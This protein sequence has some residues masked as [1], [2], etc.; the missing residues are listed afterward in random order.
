MQIM[1]GCICAAVSSSLPFM[2]PFFGILP[3]GASIQRQNG[4]NLPKIK[5]IGPKRCEHHFVYLDANLKQNLSTAAV[6]LKRRCEK[7]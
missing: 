4:E 5:K 2:L 3:G 7:V 1:D 6:P